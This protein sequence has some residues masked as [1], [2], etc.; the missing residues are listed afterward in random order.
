MA[1]PGP[2]DPQTQ[3]TRA[4]QADAVVELEMG[5][6][7]MYLVNQFGCPQ[8]PSNK[9]PSRS[10]Q[11]SGVAPISPQPPETTSR[12]GRSHEGAPADE[13]GQPVA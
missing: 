13:L 9:G 1:P 7:R 4:N 8:P 6:L 10:S 2:K 11:N 12:S 5:H 3:G